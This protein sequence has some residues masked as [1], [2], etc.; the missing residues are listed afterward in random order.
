MMVFSLTKDELH[1]GIL[2]NDPQ[3]VKDVV[4]YVYPLVEEKVSTWIKGERLLLKITNFYIEKRIKKLTHELRAYR[5][6]QFDITGIK[7]FFLESIFKHLFMI[8]CVFAYLFKRAE[9]YIAKH[10]WI[11]KNVE[12]KKN[13]IMDMAQDSLV[14]FYDRIDKAP[15][16]CYICSLVVFYVIARNKIIDFVNQHHRNPNFELLDDEPEYL[17]N[18]PIDEINIEIVSVL[19][20]I[21]V[22]LHQEENTE[23]LM[24][25]FG[26]LLNKDDI[27]EI[28]KIANEH[29]TKFR[30]YN[31]DHKCIK[32]VLLEYYGFKNNE[33][34]KLLSINNNRSFI[35]QKSRCKEMMRTILK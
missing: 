35:T 8:E 2:S 28:L 11:E 21:E 22:K 34:M 24:E 33:I 30:I 14:A 12:R 4:R 1:C 6:M 27:E 17:Y 15:G 20:D 13:D 32:I 29:I 7:D 25:I 9:H 5:T 16:D 26:T 10:Y 3:V 18:E 31:I 23:Y 19:E